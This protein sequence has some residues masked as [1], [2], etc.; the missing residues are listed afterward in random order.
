MAGGEGVDYPRPRDLVT[1]TTIP[2]GGTIAVNTL[3]KVLH[4]RVDPGRLSRA[5]LPLLFVACASSGDA[6]LRPA[7]WPTPE[8][9][10]E[11]GTVRWCRDLE[12]AERHA[13]ATDAP[14][15]LVFQEVPG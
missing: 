3:Q 5:A 12:L 8:P 11:L 10:P 2:D 13:W 7:P 14:I 9:A 6:E 4:A 1:P 15:L